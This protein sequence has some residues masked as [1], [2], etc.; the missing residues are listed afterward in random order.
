MTQA[1]YKLAEALRRI[2]KRAKEPE[3]E[4]NE[5]GL[6]APMDISAGRARAISHMALLAHEALAAYEAEKAQA[7]PA[8]SEGWRLVPIEPTQQMID[9]ARDCQDADPDASA[10]QEAFHFYRAMLAASPTP[11]PAQ[12]DMRAVCEALG[13]DPTN[14]HNAAKCPY[15]RPTAPPQEERVPLTDEEILSTYVKSIK[16]LR[17]H[18]DGEYFYAGARFAERAHG[19][20]PP[21]E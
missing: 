10:E 3:A 20:K 12:P 9:A 2:L 15:C 5:E 16:Q 19:I 13:F 6:Y 14:H 8:S 21:K 1:A 17:Y 18:N 11:P 7:V 4:P